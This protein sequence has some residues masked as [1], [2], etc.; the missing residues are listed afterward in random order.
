VVRGNRADGSIFFLA[1]KGK[2]GTG[3]GERGKGKGE[4]RLQKRRAARLFATQVAILHASFGISRSHEGVFLLFY[5][6]R[7]PPGATRVQVSMSFLHVRCRPQLITGKSKVH[8]M[9]K[10]LC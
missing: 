3:K 4:K 2:G 9:A 1:G 5:V 8:R 7:P 6:F 10:S